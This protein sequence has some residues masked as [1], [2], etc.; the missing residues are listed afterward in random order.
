M[1]FNK[2]IIIGNIELQAQAARQTSQFHQL[3]PRVFVPALLLS[4]GRFPV[5]N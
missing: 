1:R 5:M 4:L 3:L 2:F